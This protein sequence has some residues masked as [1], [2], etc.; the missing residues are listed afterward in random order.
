M[1]TLITALVAL[2]FISSCTTMNK[3]ECL[4]GEWRDA[5]YDDAT[6]GLA[7][8]RF[9]DH[10]KACAKHGITANNTVYKDGYNEGLQVYCSVEVGIRKGR[11]VDDY[12]GTCPTELEI[13]FLTGYIQGLDIALDD[14]DRQYAE[15]RD[16]LRNLRYQ[17]VHRVDTEDT[18]KRIDNRI[19]R[20]QEK[21]T[22]I[23]QER[24]NIKVAIAKW[25]NRF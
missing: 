22:D 16:N 23:N 11:L 14:L 21:L 19:A 20:L 10:A 13:G 7:P 25:V 18:A 15:T 8:E 12:R 3:R 4:A 9:N 6:R 1:K 24:V 2:S 5:G 17:R